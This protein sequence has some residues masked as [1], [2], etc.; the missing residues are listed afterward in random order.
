MISIIPPQYVSIVFFSLHL[1]AICSN[2]AINASFNQLWSTPYCLG[3]CQILM[4]DS[5]MKC[6]RR[7][8]QGAE[9]STSNSV[10]VV[11]TT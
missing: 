2:T 8:P 11:T 3:A 10:T 7:W 6:M 4:L 5:K 9:A 1:L